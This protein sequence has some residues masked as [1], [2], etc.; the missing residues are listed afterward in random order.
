MTVRGS[1]EFAN[2]KKN[3]RQIL[4]FAVQ[5]NS[6]RALAS[7]HACRLGRRILTLD[8]LQHM[9]E[10]PL[11]DEEYFLIKTDCLMWVLDTPVYSL[12]NGWTGSRREH[13]YLPCTRTTA[14]RIQ[15]Q[16]YS[17]HMHERILRC[18]DYQRWALPNP[19]WPTHVKR[20]IF[21]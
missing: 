9:Y 6:S 15:D 17:I 19:A 2:T 1:G 7:V 21:S 4:V 5:R 11:F 10:I 8:Y 12:V 13:Y 18:L 3:P 16:P 14:T 20:T